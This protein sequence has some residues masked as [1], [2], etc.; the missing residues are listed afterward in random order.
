[1][2][3]EVMLE[4]TFFKGFFFFNLMWT[5]LKVFTEFVIVLLLFYV[6]VFW[7]RGVWDLSFPLR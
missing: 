1:M 3:K 4:H 7:P 2:R 6:L 5:I